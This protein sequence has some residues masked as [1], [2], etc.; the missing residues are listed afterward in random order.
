MVGQRN[1]IAGASTGDPPDLS[2]GDPKMDPE[3]ER[4]AQ[5]APLHIDAALWGFPLPTRDC[6][7]RCGSH[8][9]ASVHEPTRSHSPWGR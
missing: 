7:E 1:V 6:V 5:T 4:Q 9:W 8:L 3:L 2:G